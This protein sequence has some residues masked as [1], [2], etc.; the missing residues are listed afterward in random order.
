ML[1]TRTAERRRQPVP[2]ERYRAVAR[3]AKRRRLG[4][5][6]RWPQVALGLAFFTASFIALPR[7]T[8]GIG[9]GV[10][11]LAGSLQQAVPGLQGETQLR[12]PGQN[13]SVGA[14]PIVDPLPQFTREL[15]LQLSGKV[16]SF[17]IQPGRVVDVALNGGSI[18]TLAI[19]QSGA[20]VAPLTLREGVNAITVTLRSDRDI[21]AS[22]SY[23][24]TVDRTPP[25]LTIARPTAGDP[26]DGPTVVVEG[27]TEP[28]ASLQINDRTVVPNPEGAFSESFTAT[29][30]PLPITVVARDK[31]GNETTTK[32]T[33]VVRE[34]PPAAG[35][36]MTVNLDR[37]T[38]KPGQFVNAYMLLRDGTGPRANV[39]LTLSVGVVTIGT[40]QTD[41]SGTAHIAFAAPT[42]EGD[43]GVVVLGGGASGRATLTVA[44]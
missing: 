21:V 32:L 12:L 34:P 37:T 8:A 7:L 14:A 5:T 22:S 17:A 6:A 25:T 30:G 11:E 28:G 16:P 2:R 27:T 3:T 1:I 18:T 36:T 19:D 20:F 31:A 26:V 24:V 13:T 4:A 38:V 39:T 9:A 42:T 44:R 10:G 15:T 35:P 41:A 23:T 43:I 40:A 33:I 29:P